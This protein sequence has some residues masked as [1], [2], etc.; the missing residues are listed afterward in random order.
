MSL[1][2]G[3]PIMRIRAPCFAY[4]APGLSN[5]Y[6]T[7]GL[8]DMTLM[9]DLV[10]RCQGYLQDTNQAWLPETIMTQ[11]LEEIA[12][13]ARQHVCG[14][15]VG[16]LGTAGVA[17]YTFDDT[18]VAVADLLYDAQSLE[19]V[20]EASLSLMRHDWER[21]QH[22]PQ[23]YTQE[24]Q[25]PLTVRLVPT[26]VTTGSDVL[27]I[28]A[29]PLGRSATNNLLAFLWSNP[30]TDQ[31]TF[32]LPDSCEDLVVFRV[33]ATLTGTAGEYQDLQKSA[34]FAHLAG[35]MFH[36]LVA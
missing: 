18:T 11:L 16:I 8:Y 23:L 20:R 12:R 35:L 2:V 1:G 9:A 29:V 6:G 33:V 5:T 31:V 17:Q 4:F 32:A 21:R 36:A 30:Q 25:A 14:T 3:G 22:P 10:T 15:I 24:L 7:Q 34:C 28:P 19:A 27:Q 13:L 26:P